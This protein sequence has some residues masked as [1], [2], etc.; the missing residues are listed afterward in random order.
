M[1]VRLLKGPFTVADY[2][3]L[4]ECG[5]FGEDDRVELIGGQVVAM[6]PI[7]RRHARCVKFLNDTLSRLVGDA[8][9]VSVQDPI[10]L[11]DESEP[12]PDVALLKRRADFYGSRHP[13]PPD[14]L[15]VIEV[16]DTS[17]DYDRDV[18]IPLYA[19]SGIYETWLADL[20]ADAID[21]HREPAGDGYANVRRRGRGNTLTPLHFPG[22]TLRVDEILG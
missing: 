10:L 17:A 3:R 22:L 1:A 18:K 8:G 2:H 16:A 15:L 11:D 4:A 21:V 20:E 13:G 5:I 7:G 12:Q 14:I 19:R 6:T 9:I